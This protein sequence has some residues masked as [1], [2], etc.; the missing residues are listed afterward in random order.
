MKTV[1]K[2]TIFQCGKCPDGRI[3]TVHKFDGETNT[4]S[5]DKCTNHNCRHQY[6]FKEIMDSKIKKI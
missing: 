6:G 5:I 4:V 3:I 2:T 1:K